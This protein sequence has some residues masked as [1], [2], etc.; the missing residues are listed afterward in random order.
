M[1]TRIL[2]SASL[3][4]MAEAFLRMV[5]PWTV[6]PRQRESCCRLTASSYLAKMQATE[7]DKGRADRTGERLASSISWVR[8]LEACFG[9][10]SG[11]MVAGM[12]IAPQLIVVST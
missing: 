8:F 11:V 3:M 1:C 4:E 7:A 9:F 12:R 10:C 5:R 6:F 2:V